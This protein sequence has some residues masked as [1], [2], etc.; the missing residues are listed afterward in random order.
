MGA[1]FDEQNGY[2]VLFE[3]DSNC[4]YLFVEIHDLEAE[5][6]WDVLAFGFKFFV[7]LFFVRKG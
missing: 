2:E 1:V 4:E 5:D 6:Y 7:E 3:V